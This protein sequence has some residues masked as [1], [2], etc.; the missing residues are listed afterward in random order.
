MQQLDV[1]MLRCREILLYHALAPQLLQ[2]DHAVQLQHQDADLV[3]RRELLHVLCDLHVVRP[4]G[5][6]RLA[7]P[8]HGSMPWVYA[9]RFYLLVRLLGKLH[10]VSEP[11]GVVLDDLALPVERE[12]H[13]RF[14]AIDTVEGAHFHPRLSEQLEKLSPD[15][16]EVVAPGDGAVHEGLEARL[17]GFLAGLVVLPHEDIVCLRQWLVHE[18]LELQRALW[19]VSREDEDDGRVVVVDDQLLA[20][21]VDVGDVACERDPRAVFDCM[22]LLVGLP[23]DGPGLRLHFVHRDPDIGARC[24]SLLPFPLRVARN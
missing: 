23:Y 20:Q 17:H 19:N 1:L 10:G 22:Q 24:A 16:F 21:E 2:A 12:L 14:V 11:L 15:D 13:E 6:D 8:L 9:M 5:R 18:L 7:V 3:H 4:I